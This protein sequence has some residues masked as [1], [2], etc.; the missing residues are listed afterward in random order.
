LEG[1]AAAATTEPRQQQLYRNFCDL[2]ESFVDMDIV[3]KNT[4]K[5]LISDLKVGVQQHVGKQEAASPNPERLIR[6]QPCS[7]Q[8][9]GIRHG[10]G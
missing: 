7:A 6:M 10:T 4:W 2:K 1:L 5:K 8:I 9:A 3:Q